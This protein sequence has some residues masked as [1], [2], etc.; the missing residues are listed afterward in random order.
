MDTPPI[1]KVKIGLGF[2]RWKINWMDGI[3]KD[4][5]EY[6]KTEWTYPMIS[7]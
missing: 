1:K 4:E 5:T 6:K 3:V 7:Q 2:D